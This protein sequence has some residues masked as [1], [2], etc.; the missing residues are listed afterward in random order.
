MG[1]VSTP[2]LAVAVADA[3]GVGSIS[4]IG[5]PTPTL[6]RLVTAMV[7]RTA[8]ALAV[9]FLLAD[10]DPVA[11]ALAARQVR[12]I[13]FFWFAP[14]P[15]LIDIAHAG[16]H[17][18]GGVAPNGVVRGRQAARPPT[19]IENPPTRPSR[20]RDKCRVSRLGVLARCPDRAV[21]LV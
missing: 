13:D 3:G 7:G 20:A 15:Q 5:V 6:E 2:D 8:G 16:G 18:Q 10:C 4:A 12:V 17:G 19:R 9:N 11:V 1:S 14:D 21:R